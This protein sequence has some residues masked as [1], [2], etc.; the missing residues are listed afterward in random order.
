MVNYCCINDIPIDSWIQ[1]ISGLAAVIVALMAI[2]HSNKNSQEALEQQNRILVCQ[3]NERKLDEYRKCLTDNMDLL[4]AVEIFGP[5]VSIRHTDYSQAKH[6][7]VSQKAKIY[8]CDLRYRYLFESADSTP[9]LQ[10]YRKY[11]DL[12]TVQLTHALDTMLEYVNYLSEFSSNMEILKNVR[13]QV[14]LYEKMI[15][16]DSANAPFY[17]NEVVKLQHEQAHLTDIISHYQETVDMHLTLIKGE[18]EELKVHTNN[19]HQLT[20]KLIAEKEMQVKELI[21]L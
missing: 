2:V 9:L 14:G 18:L 1:L 4:N 13:Q 15:Q 5:L 16:V 17:L 12:S 19:L 6:D 20:I 11:W 3:H 8:T 21:D 10:D 7:I